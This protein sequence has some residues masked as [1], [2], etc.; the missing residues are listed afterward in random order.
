MQQNKNSP[1]V[2]RDCN[3]INKIMRAVGNEIGKRIGRSSSSHKL[4]YSFER[5]AKHFVGL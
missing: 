5:P 3:L 1:H 2:F 4:L